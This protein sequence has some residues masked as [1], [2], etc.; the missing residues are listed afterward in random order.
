MSQVRT[1][2]GRACLVA[3]GR[4]APDRRLGPAP[5]MLLPIRAQNAVEAGLRRGIS[6]LIRQ[7][8]HDP[9]GRRAGKLLRITGF[10]H[11]RAFGGARLVGWFRAR[12]EGPSIGVKLAALRPAAQGAVA[13]V[14]PGAG[15]GAPRAGGDG[16]FDRQR[17][18]S[19]MRVA[20]Y[21][22]SSGASDRPPGRLILRCRT[23]S[24]SSPDR[25]SVFSGHRQRCGFG[26]GAVY[27]GKLAFIRR[28]NNPPDCLLTLL[29]PRSASSFPSLPGAS[30]PCWRIFKV[31]PGHSPARR[32]CA[33]P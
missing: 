26:Q 33:M 28:A 17:G 12:R 3:G 23:A 10:Q 22:S 16:R 29:I 4:F 32:P 21:A 18:G 8:R 31:R 11:R 2:A 1:L 15:L 9:A 19:A 20:D 30:W 25:V 27:A 24:H 6:P 7:F 14:H 5:V 13:D